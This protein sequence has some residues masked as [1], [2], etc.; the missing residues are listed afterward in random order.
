M[1]LTKEAHGGVREQQ[2]QQTTAG[3]EQHTLGDQLS[4]HP[5][6]ATT[7]RQAQGDFAL[8]HRSAAHE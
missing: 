8:A 3:G 6:P 7:N 4:N 1:S 2:A 5:Q